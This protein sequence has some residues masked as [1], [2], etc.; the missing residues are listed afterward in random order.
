[1]ED[2]FFYHCYICFQGHSFTQKSPRIC[3]RDNLFI[4]ASSDI[5]KCSIC[6]NSF[7]ILLSKN[8]SRVV[9]YHTFNVITWCVIMLTLPIKTHI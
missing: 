1:M 5:I 6:M 9:R 4:N 7:S 3:I 8:S 2:V